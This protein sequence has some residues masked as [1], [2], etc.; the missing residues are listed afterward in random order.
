MNLTDEIRIKIPNISVGVNAANFLHLQKD[1]D[2]LEKAGCDFLHFDIMDG[3][4]CPAFTF[5]PPVIKAVKTKMWKDV[6]LMVNNPLELLPQY[7][8]AGA[9]IITFHVESTIHPHRVAQEIK[10]AKNANNPEKEILCGMALNPGTDVSAAIP[11]IDDI[12]VIYILGINPGWGGQ[13][14]IPSVKNKFLMLKELLKETKGPALT[15]IDGGISNDNISEIAALRPDLI[16]SGSAVFKNG[17]IKAN[18]SQMLS[19]LK[20]Q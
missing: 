1:I 9:D 14:F 18:F 10:A 4:F 2:T 6:H 3:N 17:Q 13:S 8:A 5:G 20:N 11:F 15:V 12:D 19:A 7:I 16:V